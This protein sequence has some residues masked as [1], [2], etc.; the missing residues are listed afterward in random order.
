MCVTPKVMEQVR[1]GVCA[2]A[3]VC[4]VECWGMYVN[5][6]TLWQKATIYDEPQYV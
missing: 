3:C 6:E 4:D 5:A 2:R 1:V